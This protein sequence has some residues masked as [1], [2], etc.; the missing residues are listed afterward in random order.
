M[1]LPTISASEAAQLAAE[2]YGLQV[3]AHP[4]PGE[5]DANFR[6]TAADGRAWVLKIA[7]PDAPRARLTAQ[8]AA[9]DHLAGRLSGLPRPVPTRSDDLLAEVPLHGRPHP[10]RLLTYLPGVPLARVRAERPRSVTPWLLRHIGAFLARLDAALVDF[11][12]PALHHPDLWDLTQAHEVIRP[13]LTYLPPDLKDIAATVA[14]DYAQ[15]V[16]PLLPLLPAQAIHQDAND[17]NLL[18]HQGNLVGLVD[19]GDMRHGPRVAEVAIAAAYA[20]LDQADPLSAA[21]QVV[22][23]YHAWQP[24]TPTEQTALPLLLL[25]RLAVSAAIAA[26]RAHTAPENPYLQISAAPVAQALRTLHA[27]PHETLSARLTALCT[28]TALPPP[29]PPAADLLIRRRRLLGPNLSLHYR[30]PLHIVR[31]FGQYLYD[32]QGRAYLDCVNNVCHVGHS[33]PRVV[34]ALAQQATV[35]N[36]NTRYL[37]ENILRLAERLSATLPEPLRVWFFVNSGSEANDLALRLAWAYTGQKDVLVLEGAY[38]GNLSS[39]IAISPY[40]F[41]GPGGQGA[42]PWVH[43]LPL[44]CAYRGRYRHAA[45]PAR[46][47]GEHARRVIAQIQAQGRGVAAFIAEALM[48]TGGQVVFPPGTL[49]EIYRAVHAAGGVCIA[50]EVQIGFGRVGEAFWG[51]QTQGVIPDIVTMGKPMG[52]GHPLA[53]VVTTPEIA[54]AF[55][56]G[57]EYFNTFGGN[58]VSCAVGLAVLDVIADEG[59][60]AHAREVGATLKGWLRE[61]AER[62]PLIGDVRGLG[63]FLGVELVRDR[64]TL[65]P[66]AEESAALIEWAKDRGVLLG[67]DGPLHNVLKIK[68]PLPF[69][70]ADAERLATVIEEGLHHLEKTRPNA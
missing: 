18:I 51:F 59:L 56:N 28:A 29:P 11:D 33:H 45:D 57:M 58:P 35:L 30:R 42:P 15:K 37:H 36:T 49:R 65:A 50:D 6:L 34:A 62:H 31:G 67:V 54:Q 53:A 10:V 48:G 32:A 19:F 68:P 5:R 41:D 52:N 27:L 9:L 7:P 38:H 39:L 12:H 69:T 63:L 2:H 46:A 70:L 23:G 20:S 14:E 40:K 24:L 4:L 61:I 1:S 47:Y 64:E 55:A 60:Q 17:H 26:E 66:A 43:K 3:E 8:M 21:A 16:L 13:R 44:P 25:A 22:A